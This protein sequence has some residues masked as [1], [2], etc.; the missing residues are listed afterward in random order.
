M[1]VD[2]C[3]GGAHMRPPHLI[4]PVGLAQRGAAEDERA[5]GGEGHVVE[6]GQVLLQRRD[7]R[8]AQRR[9]ALA[10]EVCAWADERSGGVGG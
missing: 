7:A 1:L 2:V 3:S 10:I 8:L 4:S 9:V 6:A 5:G